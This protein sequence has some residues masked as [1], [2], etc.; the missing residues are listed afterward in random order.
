MKMKELKRVVIIPFSAAIG[1]II[2]GTVAVDH[3]D[4][5]DLQSHHE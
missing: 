4:N 1:D 3:I 2:G 5:I